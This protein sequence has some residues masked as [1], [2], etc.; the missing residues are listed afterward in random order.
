MSKRLAVA[1]ILCL[2]VVFL[3][4]STVLAKV[5]IEDAMKWEVRVDPASP[6]MD[7]IGIP[8]NPGFVL[9][10][11]GTQIGITHYDYQ[12]NGS[13]GN[14]VALDDLGDLHVAWMRSPVAGG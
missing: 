10:S 7:G 3:F 4:S 9:T 5:K 12:T 14:R 13:T 2:A 6:Q 8:L 1:S 11:P